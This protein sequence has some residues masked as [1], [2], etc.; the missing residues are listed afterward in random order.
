MLLELVLI[1]CEGEYKKNVKRNVGSEPWKCAAVV[2]AS[3][4]FKWQHL[5]ARCSR[6]LRRFG[7]VLCDSGSG[8]FRASCS[9]PTAW[10]MRPILTLWISHFTKKRMGLVPL[11]ATSVYTGFPG[12]TCSFSCGRHVF[13]LRFVWLKRIMLTMTHKAAENRWN[14]PLGG[15]KED[16][17]LAPSTKCTTE[18]SIFDPKHSSCHNRAMK[19]W[20]KGLMC[21]RWGV[22]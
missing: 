11:M 5:L 12:Q 20:F 21:H 4:G 18:S 19:K 6:L 14:I 16:L 17:K 10:L 15:S 22:L 8:F 13:T 2:S 3:P 1:F 9:I 7:D